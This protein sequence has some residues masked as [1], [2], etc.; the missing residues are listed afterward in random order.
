M[1]FAMTQRKQNQYEALTNLFKEQGWEANCLPI[2][3]GARGFVGNRTMSLIQQ[4]GFSKME[5]R[6]LIDQIQETAEYASRFVW[7]HRS[8]HNVAMQ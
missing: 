5:T 8:D 1:S 3:V 4:L 7:N 6:K 2:E